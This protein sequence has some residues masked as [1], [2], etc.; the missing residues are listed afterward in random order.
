M[1]QSDQLA[2][3]ECEITTWKSLICGFLEYGNYKHRYTNCPVIF[4]FYNQGLPFMSYIKYAW[5]QRVGYSSHFD[6]KLG[7]DFD[8]LACK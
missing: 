5:H 3:V 7:I 6:L 1:H 4:L 2:T 8:I